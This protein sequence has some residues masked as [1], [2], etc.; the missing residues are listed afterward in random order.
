[1]RPASR[2]RFNSFKRSSIDSE[3][4]CT[5]L[6]AGC[7]SAGWGMGALTGCS[8]AP[9]G[10]TAGCT[11]GSAASMRTEMFCDEPPVIDAQPA[12]NSTAGARNPAANFES[13][14]IGSPLL[15]AVAYEL[16]HFIGDRLSGRIQL[17]VPRH[18]VSIQVGRIPGDVTEA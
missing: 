16:H 18:D 1:M 9:P 11:G 6:P 8:A 12:A 13:A 7:G 14:F 5:A 17:L 4:G 3:G 15:G 2:N 10:I